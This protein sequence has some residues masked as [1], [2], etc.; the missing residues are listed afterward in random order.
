MREQV[1]EGATFLRQL[2]A[3]SDRLAAQPEASDGC[4]CAPELPHVKLVQLGPDLSV[5]ETETC[6]CGGSCG[7]AC[8]CGCACCQ[9][10]D[11]RSEDRDTTRNERRNHR[12]H[13][14]A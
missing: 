4:E 8:S 2:E 13:Q 6:T 12:E 7:E 3:V 1:E 10:N 9:P 5:A 14:R 11:E